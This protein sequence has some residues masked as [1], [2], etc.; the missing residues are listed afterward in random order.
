MKESEISAS[1]FSMQKENLAV[2]KYIETPR[3][4]IIYEPAT[5]PKN[6]LPKD[7]KENKEDEE[8]NDYFNEKIFLPESLTLDSS[9]QEIFSLLKNYKDKELNHELKNHRRGHSSLFWIQFQAGFR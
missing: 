7:E 4:L 9:P 6:E 8:E 5:A 3:E 2:V 1:E